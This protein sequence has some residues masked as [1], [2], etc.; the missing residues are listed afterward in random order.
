MTDSIRRHLVGNRFSQTYIAISS[1]KCG[2]NS[3]R[4]MRVFFKSDKKCN[5]DRTNGETIT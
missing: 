1:T 5:N 4:F 3:I 2:Q